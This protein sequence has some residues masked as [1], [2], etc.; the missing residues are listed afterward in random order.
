MPEC[1]FSVVTASVYLPMESLSAGQL[2]GGTYTGSMYGSGVALVPGKLGKALYVGYQQEDG[3]VDLGE[4]RG[5][6]FG[7]PHLCQQGYTLMMWIHRPVVQP[8]NHYYFCN[9]GQASSSYGISIHGHLD[10]LGFQLKTKT[11]WY[12]FSAQVSTNVWH[13]I[14]FTWS[15]QMGLLVYVDGERVLGPSDVVL[16]SRPSTTYNNFFIGKPNNVGNYYGTAILDEVL[17]WEELK[18]PDFFKTVYDSYSDPLKLHF[19]SA[20]NFRVRYDTA[21]DTA[22]VTEIVKC[23]PV[24]VDS[25][26]VHPC[27]LTCMWLL[28]CGA[29]VYDGKE[30]L[31]YNVYYTEGTLTHHAEGSTMFVK[32]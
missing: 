28:W 29:A 9:G 3:F 14:G 10:Y 12:K 7:E 22:A 30:C 4:I 32:M 11:K 31:Y 1:D 18:D 15:E 16:N 2:L 17:F 8:P 27:R 19:V 24:P 6:C 5:N 21:F 13:H 26:R 23:A 25:V 20:S